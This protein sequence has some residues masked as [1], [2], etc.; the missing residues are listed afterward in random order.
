MNIVKPLAAL[1]AGSAAA[2]GAY[3]TK[4]NWLPTSKTPQIKKS[5][6]KALEEAKYVP[7]DTSKSD[8]WEAILGKYKKVNPSSF[9][10]VSQLQNHCKGLLSKEDYSS[11]EYKEARR[12]CVEEQ[13]ITTRLGLFN[14]TPLSTENSPHADD[15]KWKLKISNHKLPTASNKLDHTFGET[16]TTNLTDIKNKCKALGAKTNDAETFEGDFSK[17]FDWCSVD[18]Q[19]VNG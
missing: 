3:L 5:I 6:S 1:G 12:W 17:A 2:T 8:K 11:S 4:D 14:K 13:S 10:E 15:D 19:S 7:L 18:T 9:T 16:E